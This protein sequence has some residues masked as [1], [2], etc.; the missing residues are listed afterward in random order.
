MS[1]FNY[2]LN[3]LFSIGCFL[4]ASCHAL[5]YELNMPLNVSLLNL[6]KLSIIQAPDSQD[7]SLCF[8]LVAYFLKL[9]HQ[10]K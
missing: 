9:I 8:L 6:F 3:T 7:V 5:V 2:L 10:N 4:S 1:S